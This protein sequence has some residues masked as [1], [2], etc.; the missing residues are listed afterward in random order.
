[1][2]AGLQQRLAW[3]QSKRGHDRRDLSLKRRVHIRKAQLQGGGHRHHITIR[4]ELIA[5][6]AAA[7]EPGHGFGQ[8][9]PI[10]GIFAASFDGDPLRRRQAPV[11]HQRRDLRAGELPPQAAVGGLQGGGAAEQFR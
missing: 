10:R 5:Q 6:I 2:N 1:M 7:L 4:Q 9:Q 8:I 11:P 3:G